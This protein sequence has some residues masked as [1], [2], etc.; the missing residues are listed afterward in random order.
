MV[1]FFLEIIFQ[2]S[3]LSLSLLVSHILNTGGNMHI[4]S[5]KSCKGALRDSL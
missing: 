3:Q 4:Q 1:Q 5:G 2:E